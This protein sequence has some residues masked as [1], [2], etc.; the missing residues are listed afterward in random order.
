MLGAE[1]KIRAVSQ[2]VR[3]STLLGVTKPT[4]PTPRRGIWSPRTGGSRAPQGCV[5]APACSHLTGRRPPPPRLV[6]SEQGTQ[7]GGRPPPARLVLSEQGTWA[8]G[9]PPPLR[10]VLSEQGTRAGGRPPPPGLVLSEH[11]CPGTDSFAGSLV[12]NFWKR[13]RLR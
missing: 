7:A 2:P 6:L 8:G 12:R 4:W 9:R 10:L 3:C 5:S 13:Q 11:G 1:R